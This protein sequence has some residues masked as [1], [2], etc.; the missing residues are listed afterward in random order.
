MDEE[1]VDKL[2]RVIGPPTALELVYSYCAYI[3]AASSVMMI[4]LG[5]TFLIVGELNQRLA[6]SFVAAGVVFADVMRWLTLRRL[7][8]IRHDE[9][10]DD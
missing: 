7:R 9:E 1:L 10:K 6:I 3:S 2:Q 8:R 4:A 5:I